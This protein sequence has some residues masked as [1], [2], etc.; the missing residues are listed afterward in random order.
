[1][2]P[3]MLLRVS[4]ALVCALGVVACSRDDS[5]S[6][7]PAPAPPPSGSSAGS[8]GH[9]EL[10]DAPASGGVAEFVA[11]EVAI[12][13]RDHTPLLVYVGATWCE[14]CRE[15]HAAVES[16][17]LDAQLGALRL[18]V[19]DLDRDGDRLAAAGYKSPLVPLF[20]KPAPDGRASG[21]QTDGV[22]KG[23]QYVDQLV[24]RVK[25]LAALVP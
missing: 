2:R 15:F 13:T 10:F 22:R 8:G 19:F 25:A 20:A 16:G 1:M 7:S 6:P 9:V 4:A 24:P 11:G 3:G 5:S 18:L 17:S 21:K 12:A 14:P 23:G